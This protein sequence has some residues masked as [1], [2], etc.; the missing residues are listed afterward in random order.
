MR[1]ASRMRSLYQRNEQNAAFSHP[2]K[3][4]EDIAGLI[5]TMYDQQHFITHFGTF[6]PDFK[7]FLC[8]RKIPGLFV[9]P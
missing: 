2:T 6:G 5:D 9:G 7:F 1:C 3:F 8:A 4:I